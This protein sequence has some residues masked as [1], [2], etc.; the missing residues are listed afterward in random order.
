MYM[1]TLVV[2]IINKSGHTATLAK[3]YA[4]SPY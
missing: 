2:S 1:Y 3:L 4:Q